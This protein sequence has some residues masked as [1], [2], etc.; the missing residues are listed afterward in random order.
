MEIPYHFVLEIRQ[1]WVHL[2]KL[3]GEVKN[4]PREI[5]GICNGWSERFFN[6]PDFSLKSSWN[7]SSFH[8]PPQKKNRANTWLQKLHIPPLKKSSNNLNNCVH[9]IIKTHPGC[10][11]NWFPATGRWVFA[12]FFLVK[13]HLPSLRT[14]DFSPGFLVQQTKHRKNASRPW[15]SGD[16]ELE[17]V[18]LGSL[19]SIPV[20]VGRC[21]ISAIACNLS[22]GC[23]HQYL[24]LQQMRFKRTDG[25]DGTYNVWQNY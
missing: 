2:S 15:K 12:P 19:P 7:W 11:F 14:W 9:F 8:P 21:R 3:F 10:V 22:H 25:T 17:T 13:S 23:R 16:S 5:K 4:M 24:F 18:S 20:K 1:T 6:L